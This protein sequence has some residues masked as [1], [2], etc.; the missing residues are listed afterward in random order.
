M[1]PSDNCDLIKA[2]SVYW[3][4]LQNGLWAVSPT[5]TTPWVKK[6]KNFCLKLT[7]S[8]G[9]LFVRQEDHVC[10]YGLFVCPSFWTCTWSSR[11][12]RFR[13]GKQS[14]S[15]QLAEFGRR[16]RSNCANIVCQRHLTFQGITKTN[17][18]EGTLPALFILH[19]S[20]LFFRV[21]CSKTSCCS[22]KFHF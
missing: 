21:P 10:L 3:A 17:L 16:T 15:V 9:K 6:Y 19:K 11:R 20:T 22:L 8:E 18:A 4:Y 1:V 13:P 14:L 5:F 7:R 2:W 12:Y